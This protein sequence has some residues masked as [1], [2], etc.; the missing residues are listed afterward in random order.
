MVR[1]EDGL[2]ARPLP[3]LVPEVSEMVSPPLS[4]LPQPTI[5]PEEMNAIDKMLNDLF[6]GN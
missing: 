4:D 1:V 2:P 3:M 5:A 6:G